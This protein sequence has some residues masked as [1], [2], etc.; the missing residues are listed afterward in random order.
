MRKLLIPM[1]VGVLLIGLGMQAAVA[2]SNVQIFF[3]TC[4]T[5]AVMNVSGNMDAG[6]DVYYQIFSGSGGTGTPLTSLRQLVVDGAYAVSEVVNYNS[7]ST[8]AA[9]GTASAKVYISRESGLSSS[10]TP[11][12]VDDIQDG[13]NNPQ[14]ALVSS[15][16]AGAGVTT[17][18]TT[19]GGSNILSPFGGVIN[20]G[21]SVTPQPLV[22]IGPRTTVNPL[23]SATPGVLFAECDQNLPGAAPG[24][25]YDNDNIVVFWSWFA[26][27]E[28][29]VQDHLAQAQYDISLNTAPLQNV[30]ISGITR[31]NNRN[32]WVF[33]TANIGHLRPGQYGVAMRLTWKQAIN[34]GFDDFGPGTDIEEIFSTCTFQI[35]RNPQNQNITDYN[36]MYSVR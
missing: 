11:F 5:K 15:T 25:L 6:S 9:G 31:P 26:K 12:V 34:D 14:N 20:P 8:V 7:G 16:D 24:L 32:Y 18:T 4:D 29:Q 33:Y 36:L 3:V 23:R 10:S 27:T 1:I 22:V 35:D 21:V 30:N 28:Q 17:T 19:T 13:C 2:E